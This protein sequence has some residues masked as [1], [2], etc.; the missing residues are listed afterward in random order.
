MNDS[1]P[2]PVEVN[3][4]SLRAVEWHRFIRAPDAQL[5][6]QLYI[7]ALSRAVR[8][9]RCCAY[10][11]SRVLSA[12]ARGFG[13]FIQ[14]L[15]RLGGTLAKP[16]ARLLVNEQLD[17]D[18][19][20]ALLATGDQTALIQKLLSQFKTPK[21]ALEKN[22]L[23]ML[24]WLVVSGWLEVRVGLM[25]R[26]RGL[27]H[28]KFGIVTDVH[29]DSLAFMGSDN[30]TDAALVENYEELE[31]RTSWADKEFTD[32]YG[33][34]FN[35]LWEDRDE[36]V[37]SLRL[38]DAVRLHLVKFAPKEP[39]SE[40]RQDKQ[41]L[42]TAMLWHFLAAAPYLPDGEYA[43][44]AT[45]LVDVWTHQGRVV[46]DTSRA[47]P[48]GR[49][50]CDEVGMGKTIEAILVLRRLL[51]GRGVKRALLLVPAGLLE[52]WQDELREKG[53]LVVPRWENGYL[54]LPKGESQRVE[55]VDALAQNDL[56]LV[57]REWARLE[58][59]RDIVLGAPEW[60]L[61]LLDE[62]HAARRATP[63]EGDFNS[64]N[65]LLQ[66]LREL[67][68]RRRARGILLLSATPMQT[69]PWEPWDLLAVLGVGGE[70][71]VEFSD[72]RNY[73]KG[74]EDLRRAGL[75]IETARAIAHL[76][77]HD[78]EFPSPPNG[79]ELTANGLIDTLV[80]ELNGE[81]VHF[82]D[83]LRQG[84][85]LARRMHRNTRDT[86]MQ[87]YRKG[88]LAL[89]PPIRKVR[90]VVFD[91][92][93][94]AER[95][96]YEAITDYIDKRYEQLE[97]EKAGKGFVMTVY[98]RR[99]SSSPRALRRSLERRSAN[100]ERVIEQHHRA[101]WLDLE[102]EGLDTRDLGDADVD[103]RVDPALPA[104]PQAAQ[105]EKAQIASL[106]ERLDA[107]GSTDSKFD[108]FWDVLQ[109]VTKDGRAVL[110]FTEY[111]DT[112]EYLR[113]Q[114]RPTFSTTLGCYSGA[115]GQLWNGQ[116]WV[117]VSKADITERLGKGELKVLICTDAAS[118][119][120]NLQA[121]S[122]LINYDLPWNPSK[123]E[124]R[125]GRIDR[126]GQQQSV[127]PIRNMFLNN[128]VDVAVYQALA[129]RC[130]LFEH[131]VGRMQ[132]VLALARDAL[133]RN[134]R[135][136]DL[137]QF[138]EQLNRTA[139]E[140]DKD[141]VAVNVFSE[142]E[143]DIVPS[144]P[145]P[146]TRQ[147]IETALR[148]LTEMK[149]SISAKQVKGQPRWRLRGLGQSI[150]VTTDRETL[151]RDKDVVPMTLGADV[152]QLLARKLVLPS[153]VPLVLAEYAEGVH[154]AFESRWVEEEGVIQLTSAMQ[155]IALIERW[156][157]TPPSP[158]LLVKAQ[159]EARDAARRR[160][161]RMKEEAQTREQ[162]N[163]R[164]QQDAA[165]SR[166]MRELA[167]TL[168]C[169]G[170][171]DLNAL[172]QKQV[173]RESRPDGRYRRALKL[174]E[175]PPG[176]IAEYVADAEAFVENLT[177]QERQRRVALPSE[178]DAALNDPRWRAN[179]AA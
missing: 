163:L 56:L 137:P 115:G 70:W 101:E 149:E 155:L 77:T 104:T 108:R 160:V 19:L 63:E 177:S 126:I 78:S 97:H 71:M 172:F 114:L 87:Y 11:S 112:M 26:T 46:E 47:F 22:R 38:P 20:A 161:E 116:Q 69:Q 129:E 92:E 74:I 75:D 62:A 158:A 29:N 79:A 88:L 173:E 68:L 96:C 30:E 95:E 170:S 21:D 2:V 178:L 34:R 134:L 80:F 168:R 145:P 111:A 154:R 55:A 48:T 130:G 122:A 98:R 151:E 166:L 61:I 113:D 140:V 124:Q 169:I 164:S 17:P 100:C 109:D 132:P 13:G 91:Y 27:S 53:G 66:L 141:A 103:E 162:S 167:R 89:P 15:L 73:Y 127:L 59:N 52:Q 50:L 99:A 156:D 171:G 85:P 106:L 39:P 81:R 121:A 31:I 150:Q 10:F 153:R 118:E 1:T 84:S 12:A 152:V 86:L 4:D 60:D 144:A 16:A 138:I 179:T 36:N 54:R 174:L 93:I 82:A 51:S 131:F 176:R 157:C 28:A 24:A 43:C 128:S 125:I 94:K 135:R 3:E 58:S 42:G 6:D 117:L 67:Q 25:R 7:P 142:S 33:E 110:V 120:L 32:Y 123:V 49:L 37:T 83:W 23:E 40:I 175:G 76:V 105:G 102:E 147:D 64:A 159:D 18:D 136:Q 41:G 107:L 133:R 90:D 35:R 57:S 143:A 119:G 44:D 45:A 146:A 9:D 148:W 72:I 65:L 5:L 8:Y 165:H 139:K 14:N